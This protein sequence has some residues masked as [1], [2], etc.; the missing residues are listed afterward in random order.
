MATNRWRTRVSFLFGFLA[1]VAVTGWTLV[2][3]TDDTS[4]QF[5]EPRCLRIVNHGSLDDHR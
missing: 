2:L 5:T 4:P 3:L 1:G